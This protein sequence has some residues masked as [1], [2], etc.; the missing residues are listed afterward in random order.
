MQKLLFPLLLAAL[1]LPAAAQTAPAFKSSC[2]EHNF[3]SGRG[4][5]R[6][7]E[8][9]DLTMSLPKSGPL[10]VDA[11]QNGGISVRSWAGKEVR[12]R[13]KVQA[14]GPDEAAAKAVVA[15]INISSA[16]GQLRARA[17]E[18]E[19]WAVSYELLVPEKLA[20]DLK[21]HNGG[22]S[23]D[24]VRGPV[25]FAA[26][27]G[28]V[29]I[30]GD[31]G[32]VRGHT[33][34]GGVSIVL[35]GKKWEGKGVDVTTTNGGVSWVVP[36]NYAAQLYSSTSHGRISSDFPTISRSMMGGEVNLALGKGGAPVKAVT[37][38]GGISIRRI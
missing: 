37:T 20:L 7:C 31:G 27:N 19:N 25:T 17:G 18:G 12:V 13:V 23:L 24:G 16:E 34:N 26:Q 9:R 6:Y 8:T 38:N 2:D 33:Q 1:T 30:V 35:N 14:W 10:Y 15:G 22:I 28:G 5:Q 3:H 29:S 36:A 4:Q 21:T 11:D 32:D